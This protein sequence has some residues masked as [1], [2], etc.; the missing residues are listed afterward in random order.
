MQLLEVAV[1]CFVVAL[2][3]NAKNKRVSDYYSFGYMLEALTKRF[4]MIGMET[5]Q[6]YVAKNKNPDKEEEAEQKVIG[7]MESFMAM[8]EEDD[9]DDDSDSD[10][11]S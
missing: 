10:S 6:K 2:K 7:Q 8:A 3:D 11:D 4:A 1:K 5:V 9:D